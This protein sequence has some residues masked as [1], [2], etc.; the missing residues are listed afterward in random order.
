M[1]INT[2]WFIISKVWI[3]KH[4]LRYENWII[5][6]SLFSDFKSIYKFIF[7]NVIVDLISLFICNT[8]AEANTCWKWPPS[9]RLLSRTTVNIA[10]IRVQMEYWNCGKPTMVFWSKNIRRVHT[11]QRRA[12]V[13]HGDRKETWYSHYFFE[14]WK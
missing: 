13:C 6:I 4:K 9:Y 5:F 14:V 7:T 1:L 2:L 10:S 8:C 12:P 11:C 3:A